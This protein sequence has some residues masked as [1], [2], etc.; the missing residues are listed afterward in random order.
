MGFFAISGLAA[1]I[2]IFGLTVVVVIIGLLWMIAQGLDRIA[3]RLA[4]I[5][6]ALEKGGPPPKN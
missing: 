1:L 3:K 4:Q 5:A 6:E 2:P